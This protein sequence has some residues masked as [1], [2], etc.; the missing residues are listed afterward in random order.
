M[1]SSTRTFCSPTLARAATLASILLAGCMTVPMDL[2]V[3]LEDEGV[4]EVAARQEPVLAPTTP[5]PPVTYAPLPGCPD[6][7]C[8]CPAEPGSTEQAEL[9]ELLNLYRDQNGLPR[10]VYSRRLEAAADLHAERMQV[11][12]FFDH[13]WPDGT[14]SAD[15]AEMAGFCHG[16]V[17][18]NITWGLNRQVTADQAMNLLKASPGHD[19]NMLFEPYRFVGI[20]FYTVATPQGN[21]YWWVQLMAL[22]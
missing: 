7:S 12:G 2:E 1:T 5:P 11:E 4:L 8:T 16:L 22:D 21:E 6:T 20:G 18:E 17:G 15:R 19:A 3:P 14:T 13:I 10:L 9:F